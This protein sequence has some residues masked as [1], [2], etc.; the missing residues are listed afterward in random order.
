MIWIAALGAALAGS[1][2]SHELV[3]DLSIEGQP[4]GSRN[5]TLKFV[6]S[7]TGMLRILESWTE[8]DGEIGPI[9]VQYKQRLTAHV[10]NDPASFHAVIDENG[11]PREIQG[12]YTPSA[13]YLSVA[14]SG[15]TRTYDTEPNPMFLYYIYHKKVK[16]YKV[17]C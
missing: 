7:D 3:W 16:K 12:R 17:F 8:I 9:H 6:K 10:A 2:V 1:P 14:D 13:W 5:M 15:R 11:S 4:I